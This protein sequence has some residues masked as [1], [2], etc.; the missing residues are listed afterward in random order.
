MMMNIAIASEIICPRN[1]LLIARSPDFMTLV[2]TNL[3]HPEVAE[4]LFFSSMRLLR[5]GPGLQSPRSEIAC[6]Q[7]IGFRQ[8]IS[9]S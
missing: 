8:M 3:L 5:Y 9:H 4:H 7:R 6:P 2:P 1:S